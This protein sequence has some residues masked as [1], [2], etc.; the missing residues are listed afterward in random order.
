M[1][2]HLLFK[3]LKNDETYKLKTGF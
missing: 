2:L 3:Q 1:P